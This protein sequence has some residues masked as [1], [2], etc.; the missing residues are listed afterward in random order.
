M[1]REQLIEQIRNA[2]EDHPLSLIEWIP[3]EERLPERNLYVLAI[4]GGHLTR[5][6]LDLADGTWR[7][8]ETN[9]MMTIDP[10]THWSTIPEVRDG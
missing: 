5:A 9:G 2:P 1:D 4:E 8:A 10:V 6:Y 3:V 7:V